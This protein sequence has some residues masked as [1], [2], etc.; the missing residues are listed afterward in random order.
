MLAVIIIVVTPVQGGNVT[1]CWSL[2]PEYE[3]I[4]V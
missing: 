1:G 2:D 4:I 3:V